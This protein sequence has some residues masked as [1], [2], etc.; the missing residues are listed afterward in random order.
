MLKRIQFF[1]LTAIILLGAGLLLYQTAYAATTLTVTGYGDFSDLVPGDGVCDTSPI[2][3][4]Q[5]SLRAAIE[6]LNAQGPDATPH[7]IEF[8]I[9]VGSGPFTIS[10]GSELPYIDVPIEID[11]ATQ[12]GAS[13][14]TASAP[15]NLLIVLDGSNAGINARGLTLDS[16]SD[17]SMI[18][19]LVIGNFDANA[20]LIW[21][22]N[23]RVRCNHIGLGADGV[24]S[25]PN[26]SY[27][28]SMTSDNN[29]IGGSAAHGRR[30]VISGNSN[31]LNISG[32]NNKVS[33]NFIGTTADGLAALGNISGIFLAGSASNNTIGGTNP[34][35]RNVIVDHFG[36]GIILVGDDNVIRGNLIGV[37]RDGTT[38]LPN[39][40][41]IS[42]ESSGNT[43]GGIGAGESNLIA[44]STYYGIR[45][46]G[47][48]PPVD[49]EMRG[50]SIYDNGDLGID[51]DGDGVDTNDNGDFDS[52]PNGF[53]NYPNLHGISDS[54]ILSATLNSTA[55]TVYYLDIYRNDTCDSTGHGEGRELVY[56]NSYATGMNGRVNVT[57]DTSFWNIS[58]GDYL[59]AL[60]TDPNGN[61]SEFSA[62]LLVPAPPITPTPTPT[63][64]NTPTSTPTATNT[65][66]PTPT[67]TST[68][69]AAPPD[70]H[71]IPA[72]F[73]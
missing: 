48:G 72:V 61:T 37:G 25:M 65:P 66:S 50:N 29:V 4:D 51:L 60:V 71:F 2:P 26:G 18:R 38:P 68:P 59:T 56:W 33:N 13:C 44:H 58:P 46:A 3:G 43:I 31:A 22:D 9:A 10:V 52:G 19:G 62:C 1:I 73:K 15:A 64:T 63:A 30:N 41:G 40:I 57:I 6:E 69:P 67:A 23:N 21:S 55:N 17:G 32:L 39:G 70:E 28:I 14:P 53:Q 36:S 49:N 16:G 5:C 20:I 24:T 8:D 42:V 11:A 47:S 45:V 35:A 34:I 7:R 27:A 12:P 54:G